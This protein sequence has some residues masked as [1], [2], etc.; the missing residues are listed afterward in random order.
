MRL[1]Y[2]H[3]RNNCSRSSVCSCCHPLQHPS[4]LLVL[5]VHLSISLP[6][7]L[8]KLFVAV[9]LVVAPLPLPRVDVAAHGLPELLFLFLITQHVTS[10]V[11]VELSGRLLLVRVVLRLRGLNVHTCGQPHVMLDVWLRILKTKRIA[12]SWVA[13]R[14]RTISKLATNYLQGFRRT[15]YA[16]PSY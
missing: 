4:S 12:N 10:A 13:S 1:R 14:R 16:L 8:K 11:V 2:A 6:I 15:A 9:L 3:Q 5:F 7:R